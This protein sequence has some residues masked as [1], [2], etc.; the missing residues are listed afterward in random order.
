M[1]P[2]PAPLPPSPLICLVTDRR[3]LTDAAPGAGTGVEALPQLLDVIGDCADAGV[4]LVQIREPGLSDRS[5]L[6]LVGGAVERTRRTA[7]RI[8]VNDRP[9]VALAAGAAGVHLK[10]DGRSADRVRALGPRGWIVGRSVHDQATAQRAAESGAIDY[11]LAGAVFRSAS[12]PGRPPLGTDA[13]RGM[14]R[15][16]RLPVLAIGGVGVAEA[17][18]VAAT[19][20]AG[21]AGIR[22]F[23][24]DRAADRRA[25]LAERVQA[26]R[27]AFDSGH[28]LF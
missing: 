5:L 4:D 16:V 13:L 2:E 7:A 15:A 9:D 6:A 20:A 22:L 24:S 28:A 23:R 10:D 3:V 19:G 11:L 12:K 26:L 8:V 21:V 25:R 1:V 14:V 18:A 17:P 27:A